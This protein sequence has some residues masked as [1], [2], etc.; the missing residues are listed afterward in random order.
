MRQTAPSKYQQHYQYVAGMLANRNGMV[1][2][3]MEYSLEMAFFRF[4]FQGQPQ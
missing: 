1:Q 3:P 2:I 4:K